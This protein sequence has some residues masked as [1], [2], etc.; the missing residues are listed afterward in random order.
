MVWGE[1]NDRG[2][3]LREFANNNKMVK[4]NTVFKQPKRRIWTWQ[5][6]RKERYHL[7]YIMIRSRYRNTV[8]NCHS[9]PGADLNSGH[10]LV[11]ANLKQVRYKKI[12]GAR[13][14][15]KW[16]LSTLANEE[17]KKKYVNDVENS[18]KTGDD[19]LP[20]EHHQKHYLE[21]C[22]NKHRYRKE[23]TSKETMGY[24]GNWMKERSGKE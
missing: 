17:I 12:K 2:S 18:V 13:K 3:M 14:R 15:L 21:K 4:S 9:Y 1:K 16:N 24:R 20:N 6:Q 5:S 22:Q 11:A 23:E 10:N 19:M 7:D 8:R